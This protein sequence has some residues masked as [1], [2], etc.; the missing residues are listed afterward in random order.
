M[1]NRQTRQRKHTFDV[2]K[3]ECHIMLAICKGIN[4]I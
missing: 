3:Q 4:Y 2:S 1:Q